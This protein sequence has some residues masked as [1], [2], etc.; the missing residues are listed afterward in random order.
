[1]C[2]GHGPFFAE[3]TNEIYERI[4]AG[5]LGLP[6]SFTKN[7]KTLLVGDENE[8]DRNLRTGLLISD[9]TL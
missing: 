2:Q 6:S 4:R 7:L 1:M 3:E 5:H 8:R 9:V